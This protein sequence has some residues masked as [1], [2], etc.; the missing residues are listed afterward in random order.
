MI[1]LLGSHLR[2]FSSS[3]LRIATSPLEHLLNI[4]AIAIVIAVLSSVYIVGKNINSVEQNGVNYPQIMVFMQQDAKATA[5]TYIEQVLNHYS[6]K[7]IKGYK[8][9]SKEEGLKELQDDAELKKI[10]SDSLADMST[11]V[12]DVLIISTNTANVDMLKSLKNKIASLPDV[13]SVEL[14]D[15]YAAKMGDLL[16]FSKIVIEFTEALFTIVLVLVIYN[17]IRLQM[18]LRQDEISVS[19]LI[20]ASDAFI[21]RPLM[22]YA[23]IQVLLGAVFAFY[24]V[25]LVVRSLNQMFL[26]L[27][28]LFGN[29]LVFH[30]LNF[31]Q[32]LN[33]FI[34]LSVFSS[35]A[36]FIAVKLVFK[37]K[38]VQ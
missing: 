23:L 25:N 17:I 1:K 30:S 7:S 8:F 15:H 31:G 37:N 9:I 36:V 10:A 29:Q 26:N 2:A 16:N 28:N 35:F 3:V 19:R 24:L 14:D 33:I 11:V 34:I 13:E 6:G 38:Y 5:T 21:M 4:L 27:H 32:M 20:G 18:M 22:Y 12:P